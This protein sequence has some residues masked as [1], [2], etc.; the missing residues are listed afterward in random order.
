[1]DGQARY[2]LA[3]EVAG[4][5]HRHSARPLLRTAKE[6]AGKKPKE[7]VTEGLRA[8]RLAYLKEFWTLT[9]PRTEHV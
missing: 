4:S 7:F 1:M 9:K 2:I 8:Y 3:Q 6:T 5:K